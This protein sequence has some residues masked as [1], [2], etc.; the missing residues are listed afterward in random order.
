LDR[1]ESAIQACDDPV[2]LG[3]LSIAFHGAIVAAAGSPRVE[4]VLRAISALV[5][6]AFFV[7]V[8]EAVD[9]QKKGTA[10]IL[11]ALRKRD[12]ERAADEYLRV[13]RRIGDRVVDVFKARNLFTAAA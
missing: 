4:V 10:A 2:E 9:V 6:G 7:E 3:R 11:R 1:I 8:G 5:P 12:A 13:M